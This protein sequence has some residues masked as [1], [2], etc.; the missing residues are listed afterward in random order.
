MDTVVPPSIT[1]DE[2]H[3]DDDESPPP[4]YTFAILSDRAKSDVK[5]VLLNYTDGGFQ[6]K[7]HF[8]SELFL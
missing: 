8:I 7:I 3:C 4:S 2:T 1:G 5:S 6:L